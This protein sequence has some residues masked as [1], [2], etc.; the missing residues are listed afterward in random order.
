MLGSS[1]DL[2]KA[3]SLDLL[4]QYT[5]SSSIDLRNQIAQLNIGLVR[6]EAH[7]FKQA[8]DENFD[9]LVQIGSLG[10]IKAIER[11]DLK[12]G[13][14][15]SSFA[16]PVIRGEIQHYLRDYSAG[17]RIPRR[18]RDLQLQAA[19]ATE[20]LH[21][22]LERNP[23]DLELATQLDISLEEL[24]EVQTAKANQRLVSLDKIV[25]NGDSRFSALGDLLPDSS[26]QHFQIAQEDQIQLQQAL[27]QLE[28]YSREAIEHVFLR[29]LTRAE[30]AKRLDVNPLTITRRIT[31]GILHLKKIMAQEQQPSVQL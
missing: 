1:N 17:L 6:Q 4:A 24:Q 27:S 23:T 11:F 7:R 8:S 31:R 12:K 28:K 3:K 22:S 30:T 14:A 21:S 16:I 25:C 20:K 19:K 10:L 9:D 5:N 15:F 13:N 26:Y 29:G 2:L 18:W